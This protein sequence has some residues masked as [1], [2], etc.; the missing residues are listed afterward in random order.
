MKLRHDMLVHGVYIITAND[1]DRLGGLAVAWGMQVHPDSF[2]I[3]VGKQSATRELIL[4]SG[5][6]GLNILQTGQVSLGNWFGRQSIR[7]ID[8]FQGIPHYLGKNGVPILSDCGAAYACEVRDVFDRGTQK[9]IV[10]QVVQVEKS[11]SGF[12]PL[13]YR[14]EDYPLEKPSHP[15]AS[16]GGQS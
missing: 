15:Y 8:K 4:S 2:L 6:F 10:G 16:A 3:A 11:S 9:L 1:Q 13:I 7:K 14:E 5:S 12:Q